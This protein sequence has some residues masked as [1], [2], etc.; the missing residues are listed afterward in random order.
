MKK[1][2]EGPAAGPGAIYAWD[3]NDKVGA[4]SMTILESKPAHSFP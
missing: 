1:T 3:G 2:F 4:G